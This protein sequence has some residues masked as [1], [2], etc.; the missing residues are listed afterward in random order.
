MGSLQIT[1]LFSPVDGKFSAGFVAI[2][3]FA[4][5]CV[6]VRSL[7][8][9]GLPR[10][11]DTFRGLGWLIL[12]A[13]ATLIVFVPVFNS[14]TKEMYRYDLGLYYLKTIRWIEGFAIVPGLA[15]VQDHLGFNQ[16]AFLAT[17]F[18]DVLVPNRWGL[19]LVGG[20]PPGSVSRFRFS[21]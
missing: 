21:P 11:A 19:F 7:F 16:S 15:N 14:C 6:L 13:A 2:S 3:S 17:S 9:R 12:L 18:F 8:A 4:A 20:T 5:L 10:K 1:H